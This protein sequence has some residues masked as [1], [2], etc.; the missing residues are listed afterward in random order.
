MNSIVSSIQ[1]EYLR[2]K[3]VA[4]AALGQVSEEELVL[5][6]AG[7]NSVAVIVWHVG[8]NLRS[9]FTDFL[10]SDGEKPWRKRDEEFQARMVS[11]ADLLAH[12]DR[13]WSAL[14]SALADL[15][16]ADLQRT[17]TI[18]GKPLSVIEALH[19]SLAHTS[20]HV[21]QIVYIA[22][23]LKGANWR[24]LSI[25]PGQSEQYNAQP[26]LEKPGAHAASVR[27]R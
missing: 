11:H 10:T 13:G 21:G 27:Q 8:G 12:W 24:F 20:Y 2:Y 4:E 5:S 7:S 19:R 23:G 25:P 6:G 3:A 9:R 15:T 26:A 18:R 1:A 16:D 22:R 14:L 17:V